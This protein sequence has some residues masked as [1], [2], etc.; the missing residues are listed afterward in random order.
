MKAQVRQ[1][2]KSSGKEDMEGINR[3]LGAGDVTRAYYVN[4]FKSN[5]SGFG[6]LCQWCASK[7]RV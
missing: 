7:T 1:S 4:L 3:D 2:G 5:T 6:F